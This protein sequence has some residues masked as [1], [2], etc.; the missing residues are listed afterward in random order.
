MLVLAKSV[1]AARPPAHEL[2]EEIGG[3][4]FGLIIVLERRPD[5][6]QEVVASGGR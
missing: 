1:T 5:R 3:L 4:R 6:A 2:F